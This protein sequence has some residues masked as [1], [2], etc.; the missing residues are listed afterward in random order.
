[1]NLNLSRPLLRCRI[2]IRHISITFFFLNQ[3]QKRSGSDY[4]MVL[5]DEEVPDIWYANLN[6]LEVGL[7]GIC[8][9]ETK[10]EDYNKDILYIVKMR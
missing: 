2:M 6:L 3:M 4:I 8:I 7:V 10:Q 1:M 9:D 5:F